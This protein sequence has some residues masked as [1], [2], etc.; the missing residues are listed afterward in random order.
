MTFAEFVEK[1]LLLAP[2]DT[3]VQA[4]VSA[5]RYSDSKLMTEFAV[6]SEATG[7]NYASTPETALDE[8]RRRLAGKPT[9]GQA[10]VQERIEAVGECST[11]HLSF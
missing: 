6:Y 8:F 9:D 1:V 5:K 7:H 2:P 3:H 11:N 4:T 10:Q